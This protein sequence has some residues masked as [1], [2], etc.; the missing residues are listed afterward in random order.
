MVKSIEVYGE[1]HRYIPLLAK[2]AGFTRIGEKVVQHRPRKYGKTKFGLE[3]FINGFLDLMTITFVG[4]FGK[5]PMH[6]FGTWG[7]L[8]F[9]AG[10]G[11]LLYLSIAKLVYLIGGIATRPLFFFGILL[12]IVGSQLFLTGFLAELI[13]RQAPERNHYQIEDRLGYAE[14]L[15]ESL[16][17]SKKK[18]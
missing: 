11:M 1:M 7:T 9:I 13:G 6:F 3:R 8:F 4:R 16:S 2:W 18:S 5:R 15:P 10:F 17:V 12:L 14:S